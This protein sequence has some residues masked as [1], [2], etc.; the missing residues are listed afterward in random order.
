MAGLEEGEAGPPS[1][2]PLPVGMGGR[3]EPARRKFDK[4]GLGMGENGRP[5]R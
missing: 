5:L 1:P 3:F 4:L 2:L